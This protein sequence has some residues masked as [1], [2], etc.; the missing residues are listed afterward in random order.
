M[1]GA[2]RPSLNKVFRQ[3][4]RQ[5]LLELGYRSIRILDRAG[6]ARHSRGRG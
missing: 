2:Q 1:L 6:L 3:F 4:E 5:G